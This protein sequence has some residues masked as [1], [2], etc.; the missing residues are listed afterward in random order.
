LLLT[1]AFI[2]YGGQTKTLVFTN[3]KAE[4]NTLATESAIRSISEALHGDVPQVQREKTTQ[5]FRSGT[6]QVLIATDVAARGLDIEGIGLVVQ[7]QPPLDAETYIHRSG[8][9]G[10]AGKSGICILFYQKREQSLLQRIE[11]SARITFERVGAPQ[12]EELVKVK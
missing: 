2:V 8:R 9:T 7:A 6:F 12:R 11:R 5:S 4:A 10:R 3:T 1:F